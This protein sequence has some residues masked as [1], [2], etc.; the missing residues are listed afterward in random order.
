MKTF[1]ALN[2][3]A[4]SP[5]YLEYARV[6]IHTAR[7]V[8]YQPV[9]LHYGPRPDIDVDAIAC[10]SRFMP[11]MEKH[12]RPDELLIASGAMLR[13]EIPF[14]GLKDEICIYTDVDVVFRRRLEP[15]IYKITSWGMVPEWHETGSYNSGVTIM[16]LP[17]LRQ[18]ARAFDEFTRE[19]ITSG[20][21]PLVCW[22]QG[23]LNSFFKSTIFR[24]P[25][26]WNW[27]PYWGPNKD[28]VILHFHGPKP[29]DSQERLD[30]EYKPQLWPANYFTEKENWM[31]L[32]AEIA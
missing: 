3:P 10:V 7:Q 30:K 27:R 21:L 25:A 18:H 19:I 32:R 24:L 23:V 29:L 9:L 28:A 6:A 2:S 12:L 26:I 11:E 16:N 4:A 14:L 22:D 31:K 13:L 5:H 20:Q 8:G 17:H 15:R 1:L